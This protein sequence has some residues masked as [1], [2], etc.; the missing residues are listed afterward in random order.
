VA[1]AIAIGSPAGSA[2]AAIYNYT[3]DGQYSSAA[4]NAPIVGTMT[5]DEGSGVTA[6]SVSS[7]AFETLNTIFSSTS[8][9]FAPNDTGWRLGVAAPSGNVY[10]YL[11]L[12]SLGGFAGPPLFTIDS[13][14]SNIVD[15]GPPPDYIN[16]RREAALS[17]SLTL[18]PTVPEPS[19]WAMMILGFFG[20]G[21]MA[22]RR[23]KKTT[24][25]FV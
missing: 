25:R 22:Y 7:S 1:G 9:T 3:L 15:I 5:F 21:F 18:I 6:L 16:T 19:T 20:I 11:Y 12:H 8:F 17:G 2:S 13:D 10:G 23:R 4:I 24:P 14:W